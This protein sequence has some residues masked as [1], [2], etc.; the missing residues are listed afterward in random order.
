MGG[1]AGGRV[2]CAGGG[3]EE[4]DYRGCEMLLSNCNAE[5]YIRR[6]RVSGRTL[7]VLN[8]LTDTLR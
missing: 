7:N 2:E 4:Q 8:I 3:G 5:G 6:G 1:D